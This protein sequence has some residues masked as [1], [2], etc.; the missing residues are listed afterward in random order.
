MNINK[1]IYLI[2]IVAVIIT[3]LYQTFLFINNDKKKESPQEDCIMCH[4]I[5]KAQLSESGKHSSFSCMNCHPKSA[6]NHSTKNP[7]CEYCHEPIEL[8]D[9]FEA[10][11]EFMPLGTEG[12]IACHTEYNVIINYSRPEYI[13]FSITNNSGNW[14]ISNI[15]TSGII[16]LSY[17]PLKSGGN[18]IVKNVSCKECHNDIF[19]A[20]SRKGHAVVMGKSEKQVPYHDT[21]NS[22]INETWCITCHNPKDVNFPTQQHSARKTT[23]EECHDAYNLSPH[24]G[25]F[26]NNIKTVPHL[27]RSLVCISCKYIGWQVPNTSLRFKVH[28]EP[29]FDVTMW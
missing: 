14:I 10:H 22:T 28:Q 26:Y 2:V 8:A 20:V 23:C 7:E 1:N 27:Y 6:T 18:H 11:S 5:V 13:Y 16:N 25:N 15:T 12:C 24:P 29:Y 19:D 17:N 4:K 3:T 9:K 21:G